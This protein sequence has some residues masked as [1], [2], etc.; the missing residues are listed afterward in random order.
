MPDLPNGITLR[1]ATAADEPFLRDVYADMRASELAPLSWSAEQKRAFCDMQYALQDRHYREHYPDAAF[2]V[3]EAHDV[4]IGRMIVHRSGREI[5][6]MDIAIV[7]SRR[8]TGIGGALVRSLA[9]EADGDGRTIVLYVERDNPV[10]SLYLR[11]GFV[12]REVVGV[13][14]R[15]SRA[16]VS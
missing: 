15:M 13:Y 7:S 14:V 11:L 5:R 3:I 12:E 1:E 16:P 10:R 6:L 4:P 8:G 2:L 9:D